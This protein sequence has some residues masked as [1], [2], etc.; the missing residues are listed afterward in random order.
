[1]H[2]RTRSSSMSAA[3]RSKKR[4]NRW[5]EAVEAL[6][7]SSSRRSRC[8]SWASSL[9]LLAPS[10]SAVHSLHLSTSC[11]IRSFSSAVESVVGMT[12]E[13]GYESSLV[14]GHLVRAATEDKGI[15]V[16]QGSR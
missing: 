11:A 8:C 3:W 5:A 14:A 16:P 4:V 7:F 12:S 2:T 1:M 15:R 9:A 10:C 6:S 13:D